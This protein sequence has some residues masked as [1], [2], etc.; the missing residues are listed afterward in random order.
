MYCIAASRSIYV[1]QISSILYSYNWRRNYQDMM[2]W[3]YQLYIK[4]ENMKC[5]HIKI[6]D[7]EHIAQISTTSAT[8]M[9]TGLFNHR[10]PERFGLNDATKTPLSLLPT[11]PGYLNPSLKLEA[12][13][14]PPAAPVRVVGRRVWWYLSTS[15]QLT[16]LNSS[17]FLKINSGLFSSQQKI[18]TSPKPSWEWSPIT[19]LALFERCDMS[20]MFVLS[21]VSSPQPIFFQLK[22]PSFR[23]CVWLMSC[24]VSWGPRPKFQQTE[25][26]MLPWHFLDTPVV[27]PPNTKEWK[28][29]L[30]LVTQKVW[31][32]LAW[33]KILVPSI[34]LIILNGYYI[35]IIQ[36][37]YCGYRSIYDRERGRDLVFLKAWNC[38]NT[39]PSDMFSLIFVWFFNWRAFLD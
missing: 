27:G 18:E 3:T 5:Q 38:S 2:I 7:M 12:I 37:V 1:G 16:V 17:L 32:P 34:S 19:N 26:H 8:H 36:K 33:I 31:S 30:L 13:P 25:L 4:I 21:R 29:G 24:V 9:A 22:I 20:D 10:F 15:Q 11:I 14:P 6:D 35:C 23:V 39:K 28:S